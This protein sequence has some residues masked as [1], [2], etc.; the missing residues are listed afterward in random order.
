MAAEL[1][2]KM[3]ELSATAFKLPKKVRSKKPVARLKLYLVA[4]KATA[5]PPIGPVFSS[6]GVKPIEFV[7]AFNDR[8][9]SVFKPGTELRVRVWVYADKTLDW[10][11]LPPHSH[12]FLMK[13]LDIDTF[14]TGHTEYVRVV[15]PQM[16]Y[17]IA[18]FL[19]PANDERDLGYWTGRVAGF[20]RSCGVLVVDHDTEVR[21][22]TI[23]VKR[24]TT[25][26]DE[27]IFK[28]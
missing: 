13:A 9:A 27:W 10:W 16:C 21:T 6:A 25:E 8:T 3:L 19:R 28:D 2:K 11:I 12:T 5:G 4:G 7:R 24:P 18:E 26:K 15:T 23:E 14:A 20:A 1:T 17:H 22:E